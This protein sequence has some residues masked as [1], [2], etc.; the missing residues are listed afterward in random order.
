MDW[1][2][3]A[4]EADQSRWSH[5]TPGVDEEWQNALVD[6]AIEKD[7]DGCYWSI[8]PESADRGGLYGTTYVAGS[9]E[10]GWGTWTEI[11]SR[12]MELLQRLW[13]AQGAR[14]GPTPEPTP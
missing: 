9:N 2:E 6:Y 7:I 3:G 1:P 14:P 13:D 11:D 4:S 10:S 12:K 8:Y 5:I